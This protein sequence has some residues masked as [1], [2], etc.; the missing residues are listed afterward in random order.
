MEFS[1]EMVTGDLSN[2]VSLD[3]PRYWIWAVGNYIDGTFSQHCMRGV[4]PNPIVLN[5]CPGIMV[6]Y[7]PPKH[8]I[9]SI[10]IIH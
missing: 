2:D 6:Y 3:V 9:D 10:I 5:D 4:S 8:E 1:R 7:L